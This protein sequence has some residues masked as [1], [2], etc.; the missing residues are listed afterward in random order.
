MVI[1]T[2]NIAE[3][4]GNYLASK[5]YDKF[6]VVTDDNTYQKCFPLISETLLSRKPVLINIKSGDNHKTIEQVW[7]IWNALSNGGA[8]RNS[9]LINLGGGMVT[10]LAGFA[11]A[12]FKRGLHNINIP[13]TLMAS[14]DAAIGGKTGVNF[15]GLKNEIGSFYH[16]DCVMIDCNFLKTLDYSN[17]LSGYSEMLKHGLIS[18]KE[19]FDELLTYD[20]FNFNIDIISNLVLVS[21]SIKE[22]IVRKDP[23]EKGIRK[24]LN[25]GHTVGHAIESMSFTKGENPLLHGISVAA[26]LIC[27][28]YLSH[29]ILHLP[30]DM[31]RLVTNFIKDNYP[32]VTLYCKDYETLYELMKHDKKNESGRI[33]FTLLGNI[34]EIHINQE[35]CKET[36]FE[37]LDFYRENCL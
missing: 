27:E 18:N 10:D 28:L 29:K 35:V 1:I 6:F 5:N 20:F 23:T 4:L 21:V 13:T 3:E 34:G 16:P 9:A 32:A 33:N 36:V 17:I 30:V 8:S 25:F 7:H 37:S 31:L 11:G 12:T 2:K 14:V 24:A 22:D 19:Y 15:N 26:G